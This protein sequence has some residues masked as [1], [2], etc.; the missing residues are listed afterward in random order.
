MGLASQCEGLG[1]EVA[2]VAVESDA[3]VDISGGVAGGAATSVG[4]TSCTRRCFEQ[5]QP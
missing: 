4:D 2:S 5:R 1:A 3:R